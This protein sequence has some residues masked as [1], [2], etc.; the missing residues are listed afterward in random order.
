MD[1]TTQNALGYQINMTALM[2][3]HDFARRIAHLG[4]APEQFG[5][6]FFLNQHP[7]MTQTEIAQ[8]LC[9][10]KTTVT[11]MM[12]A[13]VKKGLI[14]KEWNRDDRR[15]QTIKMTPEGKETLQAG[16]PLAYA[17]TQ[18]LQGLLNEAERAVIFTALNKIQLF[19]KDRCKGTALG[20]DDE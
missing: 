16:M 20:E 15:T 12:D 19:C 7:G 6:L 17:M 18:E 3:R 4:I 14:T 13:L 5:I 11:R 1:Y 9:K 10:N 2:V 8:T